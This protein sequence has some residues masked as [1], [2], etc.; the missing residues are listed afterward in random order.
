MLY[1]YEKYFNSQ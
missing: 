1:C